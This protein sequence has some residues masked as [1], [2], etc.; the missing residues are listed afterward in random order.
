MTVVGVNSDPHS[1]PWERIKS[2][3]AT[4]TSAMPPMG[5]ALSRRQVRDLIAFLAEQK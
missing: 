4:S 1:V 3:A 5:G 2:R